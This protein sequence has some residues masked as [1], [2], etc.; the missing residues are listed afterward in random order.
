MDSRPLAYQGMERLQVLCLLKDGDALAEKPDRQRLCEAV[1]RIAAVGTQIPVQ[2]IATGDPEV[3][4]DDALTLLVHGG[5]SGDA[6]PRRLTL[7]MR[8][9]R[10]T[11]GSDVLFGATPRS[12]AFDDGASLEAAVGAAL[13]EILPWR[14]RPTGAR[15]IN[16]QRNQ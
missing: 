6:S 1:A 15:R 16:K 4:A 7:V 11:A 2:I 13:D 10:A 9:Y 5:L 12:V 14:A 8:P 3:I